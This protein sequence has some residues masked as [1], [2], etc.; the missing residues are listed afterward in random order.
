MARRLGGDMKRSSEKSGFTL[1]ELL[2]VI[3]II[4]ILV[5]LLLPAVQAAREAPQHAVPNNLKNRMALAYLRQR[6]K[7]TGTCR[8]G[9]L[10]LALGYDSDRGFGKKRPGGFLSAS[11]LTWGWKFPRTSGWASVTTD[12][13]DDFAVPSTLSCARAVAR[14]SLR[15][16]VRHDGWLPSCEIRQFPTTA[17]PFAAKIDLRVNG[18]TV[19]ARSDPERSWSER[20]LPLAIELSGAVGDAAICRC[21]VGIPAIPRRR[22]RLQPVQGV[23]DVPMALATPS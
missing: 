10:G 17:Y 20:L 19:L 6:S 14:P 7:P 4:G 18:E 9:E 1:V 23:A 13:A 16:Q 22:Q 3:T 21:V 15:L 11:S 12:A 5:G 2:I 8:S